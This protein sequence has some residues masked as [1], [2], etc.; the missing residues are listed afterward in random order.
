MTSISAAARATGIPISTLKA[1]VRRGISLDEALA[2]KVNRRNPEEAAELRK[3]CEQAGIPLN[4]VRKR[5]QRGIPL[6]EALANPRT[7]RSRAE[8]AQLRQECMRVGISIRSYYERRRSGMSHEQALQG[9]NERRL[10]DE[11]VFDILMSDD[12]QT[13]L[14]KKHR[15][16]PWLIAQVRYGKRYE[17]IHP[18]IPRRNQG[19]GRRVSCWHCIHCT[20]VMER[21]NNTTVPVVRCGIGYPD[22]ET[23]GA[24]F[25]KLCNS[26]AVANASNLWDNTDVPLQGP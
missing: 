1:R 10:D 14:A 6:D 26:Y 8:A 9:A 21:R 7:H 4:T 15:C 24:A 11:Q 19:A 12:T 13:A 20:K 17:D 22:V 16:S 2:Y 18:E 3:R 5:L 25:A 23:D